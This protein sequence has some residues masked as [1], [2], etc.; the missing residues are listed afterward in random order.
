MAIL[1]FWPPDNLTPR[2]QAGCHNHPAADDKSI[3]FGQSG[4]G[5][6]FFHTG[7]RVAVSDIF[8]YRVREK[9]DI[10]LNYADIIGAVI[11][12]VTLRISIPSMVIQ[13]LLQFIETRQQVADRAFTNT[14]S[15]DKSDN[16]T[17]SDIKIKI[18]NN[19]FAG[20]VAK[21]D[22]FKGNRAF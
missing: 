15:A 13:A 20:I 19:R 14:C 22:I 12:K 3:S 2:H 5:D 10:L 21:A 17:G 7:M 18:L 6:D 16:F 8:T 9:E 11:F 4:S 1:C